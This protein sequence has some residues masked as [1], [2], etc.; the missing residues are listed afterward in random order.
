MRA[1][2]VEGAAFPG[3]ERPIMPESSASSRKASDD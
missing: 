3:Y 1:D 2:I